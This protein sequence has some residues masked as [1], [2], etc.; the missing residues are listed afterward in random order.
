M[1]K[2]TT[3]ALN[4]EPT[5]IREALITIGTVS[6]KLFNLLYAHVLD[7]APRHFADKPIEELVNDLAEALESGDEVIHSRWDEAGE[8]FG[9]W[10]RG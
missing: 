6:E 4:L 5:N 7:V 8:A 3:E 10:R 9:N 2:S 1:S